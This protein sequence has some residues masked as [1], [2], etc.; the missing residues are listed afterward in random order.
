M[1]G[2]PDIDKR[3]G[4]FPVVFNFAIFEQEKLKCSNKVH[5]GS[6]LLKC[7]SKPRQHDG[8]KNTRSPETEAAERNSINVSDLCRHQL[9]CA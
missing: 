8:M 5:G 1:Y 4:A 7:P 3:I 6:V 9:S 2:E